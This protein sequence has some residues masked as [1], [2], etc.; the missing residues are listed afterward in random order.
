MNAEIIAVGSEMLTPERVDTNSLHL[1][2]ELNNLGVEVVT[3]CVI[4]DDRERLTDAVRRAVS[5]SEIVILSGG[6]GPT[7]DDLTREAVAQAL[8]RKLIF[9]DE[10]AVVLERRFAQLKR[11]MAEI[12]KRQAF[13]IEGA[14]ALPNDRG[15]APGQWVEESGSVIMLLP[16]PPHELKAMF[17][18]QCLPRLKRLLPPLAIR[19]V[20]LRV[21]GMSES[22][23]DALI[24]PVYT[25]YRNPVTTILAAAGDLQIHL[26]ARCATAAEADVL[27]AE[28]AGPIELLLGDRLYSRNGDP[29][30]VV[31]GQMLRRQHA[32]V[33]VAE[34]CTGGM[35][36]ERLTAAP[37]SSDY[38]VGG[39]ITYSKEM[40]VQ[41][42][43]VPPEVLQ[44]FGAVSKE[45]AEAMAAGARLHTASTYALSVTGVA[46]P[47]A[48]GESVPVGTVYVGLAD[49]AGVLSVHR[50]F[51][52][53]RTRIRT[54]TCQMALDLLRRR[55]AK[56]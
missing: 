52:G 25:K 22:D 4:G 7:E 40:K 47:D 11:K 50:Q 2:A 27:L 13:L 32:T 21:A 53:D 33:S 37:G 18:R 28:V 54:F 15:T 34:S 17:E 51:I 26:R 45:T 30:D 16:G 41:L 1:T 23:L 29:L 8:G 38:F 35:L 46:G 6:L 55:M 14:D 31:V 10:L 24:A 36:G 42:L 5:R 49:A 39:F 3:K 19:T 56:P 20:F 43:G 12:N 44:Q 48:G 9:R